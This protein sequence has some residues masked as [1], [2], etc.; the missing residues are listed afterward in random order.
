MV[1]GSPNE[2]NPLYA[3]DLYK[4]THDR[5][6]SGIRVEFYARMILNFLS[7]CQKGQV[8]KVLVEFFKVQL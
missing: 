4:M 7:D 6:H 3:M 2:R 1:L 5:L 8:A